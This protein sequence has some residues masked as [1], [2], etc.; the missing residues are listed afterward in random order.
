MNAR[1]VK[2][3]LAALAD[4]FEAERDHLGKLDAAVG[5]G[6]H[7]VGMARGFA[8]ARDAAMALDTDD[9]GQL[10][11]T[12]G[13]ALMA[14][15]GGAS[16]ALFATLFL[17]I[18]KA[19]AGSDALTVPHLAA[20]TNSALATIGR[21]GKAQLGDKTMLDALA[22][23]VTALET[24]AEADL[25]QALNRAAEAAHAGAEA[26][27]AMPARRG[28]AQ[29]VPNA[30]VGHPDPGAVSTTLIFTTWRD[31]ITETERL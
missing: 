7:G 23:V 19:G 2:H 20:G 18:G 25:A 1:A 5:D 6:D 15:V 3:L 14:G 27:A 26:T 28:R 21:L 12:A 24:S 16:G 9:V 22:P 10:L 30:G 17:D 4:T 11:Q 8:R 13:R 29:Y 31:V